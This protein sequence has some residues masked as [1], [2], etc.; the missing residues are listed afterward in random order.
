MIL[1][2][3]NP[4]FVQV[5]SSLFTSCMVF[6]SF[7]SLLALLVPS[8]ELT[9]VYPVADGTEDIVDVAV[10]D[11]VFGVLIILLVSCLRW[12]WCASYVYRVVY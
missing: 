11:F 2:C 10:A 4:R 1:V 9:D 5:L 6:S 7:D 12:I 8:V 3:P